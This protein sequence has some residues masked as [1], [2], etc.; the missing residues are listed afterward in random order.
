MV[1]RADGSEE[2]IFPGFSQHLIGL[3][4]DDEK[5]FSLELPEDFDDEM[6]A[7]SPI[8]VKLKVVAVRSRILPELDDLFAQQMLNDAEKTL[9]DLRNGVREDLENAAKQ[10]AE[11]KLFEETFDQI[12]EQAD[13]LY[14]D[15]MVDSYVES[16]YRR[17]EDIVQK[18]ANMKMTDYLRIMGMDEASWREE[19]REPSI[20]R[21]ERD[22]VMQEFVEQEQLYL[23]DGFVDREVDRV[24]A[25][26]GEQASLYRQ[27]IDTPQYRSEIAN[28]LM[29]NRLVKRMVDIVTGQEPPVGPD[30]EPEIEEVEEEVPANQIVLEG[31]ASSPLPQAQDATE[32]EP[33]AEETAEDTESE[34][35]EDDNTE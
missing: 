18:Q 13:I 31:G 35:P 10:T 3:K 4:V 25:S 32:A 9:L 23:Q 16:M 20:E 19:Q 21:L 17:M 14:P 5:E 6:M 7:G 33:V 27:L 12:L 2:D 24:A 34:A 11:G 30:P 1:V 28:T 8:E 26:F 22:L 15:V 29:T